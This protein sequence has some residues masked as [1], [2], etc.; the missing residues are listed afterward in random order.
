MFQKAD[1]VLS[2]VCCCS[3]PIFLQLE[4]KSGNQHV[5]VDTHVVL[6]ILL[7]VNM[8][9]PVV[10]SAY[11]SPFSFISPIQHV[12]PSLLRIHCYPFQSSHLNLLTKLITKKAILA[13]RL[14][15]IQNIRRITNI[16]IDCQFIFND[17]SNKI[18]L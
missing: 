13:I 9:P 14:C 15:C 2:S 10:M 8:L 7:C 4:F 17:S 18:P 16:I 12:F 6:C 5:V 1:I 11:L 3:H